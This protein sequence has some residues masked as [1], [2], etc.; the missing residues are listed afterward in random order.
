MGINMGVRYKI[1]KDIAVLTNSGSFSYRDVE[2]TLLALTK[3]QDYRSG[4][5]ILFIDRGSEY[6]PPKHEPEETARMLSSLVPKFSNRIAIV[7]KKNIHFGIARMIQAHCE[8]H[9]VTFEVFREEQ[10]ARIWLSEDPTA[11]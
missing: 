3:D 7:V 8:A 5:R 1:E 10:A 11:Q 6:N 9:E 4:M 2:K